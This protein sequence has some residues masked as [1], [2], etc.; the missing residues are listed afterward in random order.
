MEATVTMDIKTHR[1]QIPIV[2]AIV[3]PDKFYFEVVNSLIGSR[4]ISDGH[5]I[6]KYVA[7]FQQYTKGSASPGILPIAEG[8]RDILAGERVLD[9]LQSAAHLR[10]E[11]LSVDG[12]QVDCDV[13]EA[14]YEPDASRNPGQDTRKKLWV[15]VRRGL[16]LKVSSLIR[17]GSPET[18]GTREIAQSVTVT[19]IKL[20]EPLRDSLFV[21]VAPE[22]VKEVAELAPPQRDPEIGQQPERE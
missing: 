17:M 6:W 21:F 15:D 9:G 8:P 5:N 20:N 16:I 2:G 11:E 14:T 18:G 13:V 12:K 7:A 10:R 1:I 19:S 22:G 3:K 4:T